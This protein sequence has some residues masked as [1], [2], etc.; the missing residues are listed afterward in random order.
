M[1]DTSPYTGRDPQPQQVIPNPLANTVQLILI[2]LF[3][4]RNPTQGDKEAGL[5]DPDVHKVIFT[6]LT[7]QFT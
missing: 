5:Q 1:G 7:W 3:Q 4:V 6:M 2:Q